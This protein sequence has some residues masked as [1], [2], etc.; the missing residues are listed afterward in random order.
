MLLGILNAQAAAVT[1]WLATLGGASFDQGESLEVD[2]SNNLYQVGRQNSTGAGNIDGLIAKYNS[3][4][5]V[6]WQQSLGGT[7]REDIYGSAIDSSD[8]VFELGQ[9]G[10][11]G[12][13]GNDFLLAKYNSSGVIQWQ[14]VLGGTGDE[15]G[16]AA[17]A[18]SS[19]NVYITGKTDS[20]G[21]GSDSLLLAKYNSSGTIQWQRTLGGTDQDEGHSLA[22]DSSNN[23][24]VTGYTE[25]YT[26]S[27]NYLLLAKYNSSGTIQWQRVLGQS[28]YERGHSVTV[29]TSDNVYVAGQIISDTLLAKYNS[30]GTLQWQRTMSAGKFYA[31]ATDSEDNV[32]GLGETTVSGSDNFLIAKYNTSGT[33]QWQRTLGSSGEVGYGFVIDSDDVLCLSGFSSGAGEGSRDFLL[34]KIPNDGSLTGTYVLNG[35]NMVYAASS[36]TTATST[37][38]SATSSLTSATS[39]LTAATSTLTDSSASLTSHFVEI[40]A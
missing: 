1:Y 38:T 14:R 15:E 35:V 6:Q 36:L 16:S 12:A 10:S 11:T 39:S 18:D 19:G 27:F 7:D 9:T 8:N 26:G 40:P 3:S 32:Y 28:E 37:L 20:V 22:V 33:I 31:L 4:G 30:S 21:P 24:Y 2:S 13:G 34:A 23:V 5:V 17:V 29:D 25:S